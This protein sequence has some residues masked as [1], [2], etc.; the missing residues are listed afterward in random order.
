MKERE[1]DFDLRKRALN[2]FI[3]VSKTPALIL[4]HYDLRLIFVVVV[5]V[6]KATQIKANPDLRS[7]SS[8]NLQPNQLPPTQIEV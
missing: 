6:M 5:L 3:W 4:E 7:L 8:P 1:G 2:I